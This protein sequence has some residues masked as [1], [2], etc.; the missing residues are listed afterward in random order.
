[1]LAAVTA[2]GPMSSQSPWQS[3]VQY[4]GL[5]SY[6]PAS[7]VPR[8]PLPP[9]Q[10][11][12]TLAQLHVQNTSIPSSEKHRQMHCSLRTNTSSPGIGKSKALKPKARP[13]GAGKG[14][15]KMKIQ[16]LCNKKK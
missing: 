16:T 5:H 14:I 2:Y 1:M 10:H 11:P 8:P 9:P 15:L 12:G 7:L 6:A 3:G 4:S 13:L